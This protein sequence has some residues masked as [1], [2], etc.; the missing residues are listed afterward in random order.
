VTP[1]MRHSIEDNVNDACSNWVNK[2]NGKLSRIMKSIDCKRFGC[3]QAEHSIFCI[4]YRMAMWQYLSNLSI[5]KN[6]LTYHCKA[7][8]ILY[9]R[10]TYMYIYVYIYIYI[11]V[12]LYKYV[13]YIWNSKNPRF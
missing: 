2:S 6:V 4:L 9:H 5:F 11:Y 3:F 12:T 8:H 13:H 7:I 10:Y 1:C